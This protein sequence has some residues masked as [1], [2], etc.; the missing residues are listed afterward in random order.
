MADIRDDDCKG[1]D[2]SLG[3]IKMKMELV[4]QCPEKT[5]ADKGHTAVYHVR[6]NIFNEPVPL[7]TKYKEF[8]CQKGHGYS[9]NI[10]YYADK[11]NMHISS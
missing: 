9:N 4:D 2:Q 1:D 7:R 10:D 5:Y 8:V 6:T 3:Q 11:N